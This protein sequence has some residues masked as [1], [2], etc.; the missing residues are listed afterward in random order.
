MP[1]PLLTGCAALA[2]A[3]SALAL[4]GL[5]S[6]G[7]AARAATAQ[8]GGTPR[9]SLAITSV[10]P[11]YARPG[12]TVT[13]T[14]T[15]T[16]DSGTALQGLSV[17][18][19]SSSV[20]IGSRNELQEY[21]DGSVQLAVAITGA[22]ADLPP[23]VAPRHTVPWRV[24][25]LPSQVPLTA[26]GVYPLAADAE[27]PVFGQLAEDRTFLPYW[28]GNRA[29]DLQP[30]QIA[31]VWPLID[32]PRQA[33]CA[34]QL[35]NNGLAASLASGGRLSGL[36]EAGSQ[37]AASAQLTWAVDPALLANVT[38]MTK[39]YVVVGDG[40]GC[41]GTAQRASPAAQSWLA[42]LKAATAG[43]PMFVTPYADAD[44]AAL[45]RYGMNADLTRAF[46]EGRSVASSVLDR[47][48]AAAAAG[49]TTDLT[50][51]AWPADGI[52]NY[53]VLENL[54]ASDGI[55]T[56]VLDSSTMPPSPQQDFTPT[57]QTTTPDGE[58]SD[59]K[60]LLADG[61]LTQIIASANS[62]SDSKATAFA[63]E[64]RYLAETAMIA[65]EQPN[66]A[67]SIVVTPPRRWD[68]PAGLA[69]DLLS[70]TVNA[71]WLRPTSLGDLAAEPHPAGQVT[72]QAPDAVSQA[73]LGGPLLAQ[74]RQLDQQV[75]LLQGIQQAPNPD[76][77]YGVAAVESGAWRGGG[78][79]SLQGSAQALRFSRYLSGQ[80]GGLT[81]S[82]PKRVTLAGLKGGVPVSISN[83]L[84]YTVRV[85]LVAGPNTG[86]T[87]KSQAPL[88]VIP[89]GQQQIKKVEVAA[90]G[91]GLATLRL[92]L[93]TPEGA[94]LSAHATV[95]I[96]AT[97][98]GTLALVIIGTALGIFVLTS[99]TRAVR[100]R[101]KQ[102]RGGSSGPDPDPGPDP[103]PAP[104]PQEAGHAPQDTARDERD[105]RADRGEADNV[106]TGGSASGHAPAHDAAKETDDYAW[107]PGWADPR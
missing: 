50:G 44:I 20:A 59:L 51:M 73:E 85:K 19:G 14:G 79:A 87:V 18:L 66:L 75:R 64:Q 7:S 56:V 1:R 9:V 16:N 91:V 37:Y 40:A 104:A 100:R 81:I 10:G 5:A 4:A 107:A 30:Q 27:S 69:S 26:F 2:V 99:V 74:A 83:G 67:R 96:Q 11:A 47:D 97:H 93:A 24:T 49:S 28:P 106:V 76:L 21:A 23:A 61:T 72:R 62:P 90:A 38:T 86:I 31:W 101:R 6:P 94:P 70:E 41:G 68:P 57:A 3:A 17:Q 25:L 80:E 102:P 43:Q 42:Q 105:W 45:T 77:D 33:M 29:A 92:R 15:L 103:G 12:R 65:A 71:P 88:L 32:Q 8:P 36:L 39:P 84:G 34:G 82:G 13:V 63:V 95:Y 35:L 46:T 54:A 52:A 48:F 58:G 53:G 22:A 89:P 55:S 60:V 78:S 98:Y